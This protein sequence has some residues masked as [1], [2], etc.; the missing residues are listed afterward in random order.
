MSRIEKSLDRYLEHPAPPEHETANPF[1]LR[2]SVGAPADPDEFHQGAPIGEL[3]EL[4]AAC[5][6]ARLFEDQEYGQWGV[7][8]LDPI[9]S[10]ERTTK[11]RLARP[12][13]FLSD[14]VVIGEFIGDQE[15][16][17]VAPSESDRRHV[18]VALPLDVRSMWYA[19]AESVAEF[20]DR[21]FEARGEKYWE[22]SD[23]V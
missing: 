8:L 7:A 9:S 23:S 17:V 3:R 22:V 18:L 4:W 21:Y 2:S 6:D 14:D 5:R 13:E 15:L 19:A 12:R 10:K 20:L 11:E 1:R 16:L